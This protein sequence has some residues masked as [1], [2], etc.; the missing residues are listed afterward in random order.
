VYRSN[1]TN[2]KWTRVKSSVRVNKDSADVVQLFFEHSIDCANDKL[3]FAFTYPYSYANLQQ[4]LAILDNHTNKMNEEGSI[5]YKRELLTYSCDQR[6]I[7]LIT[8]SSVEGAVQ[9]QNE[10]LLSGLFPDIRMSTERPFLFPQKEVIFVSARV[11]P[12]EVPGQHAFNGILQF[13]MDPN[14]L[15]A[16]ELRARYVIKLIPM[17]NPDGK[18]L[19]RSYLLF[20]LPLTC[21]FVNY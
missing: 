1:S 5:Y 17:L 20:L 11:H 18:Y 6:R 14:D 8:I 9:T 10:P 21:R 7:D 15:C 19:F 3:F 16:K 4:D 12:G 2:Q 13:L